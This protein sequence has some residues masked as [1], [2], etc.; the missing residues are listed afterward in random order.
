[1]H[2]LMYVYSCIYSKRSRDLVNRIWDA[3]MRILD[4]IPSKASRYVLVPE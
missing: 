4:W 2:V 1:M 3:H